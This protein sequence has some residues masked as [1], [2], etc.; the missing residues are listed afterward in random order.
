MDKL[1]QLDIRILKSIAKADRKKIAIS[2]A[3]K[4]FLDIRSNRTLRARIEKLRL[5]GLLNSEKYPGCV[6]LSISDRG[7]AAA[8][9]KEVEPH[10][11]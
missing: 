6:L 4:P 5:L 2:Q 7:E 8:S 9:L 3:I 11:N 10:G 1:D